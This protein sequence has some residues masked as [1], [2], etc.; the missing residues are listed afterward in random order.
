MVEI[1]LVN[2]W[3]GIA[4]VL[5]EYIIMVVLLVILAMDRIKSK[6]GSWNPK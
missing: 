5:G 3:L 1:S 4:L 6:K 2:F